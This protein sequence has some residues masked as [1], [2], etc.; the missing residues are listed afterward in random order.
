MYNIYFNICQT[1]HLSLWGARVAQWRE[2]SPSTMKARVLIAEATSYVG[3][4]CCWFSSSLREVFTPGIQVYP[5]PRPLYSKTKPTFPNSNSIRNS[6]RRTVIYL[7]IDLFI[8]LYIYVYIYFLF[9]FLCL[10]LPAIISP[11]T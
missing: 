5:A 2:H 9:I 11:L 8:Y 1:G 10:L 4:V 7:F 6:R 3:R